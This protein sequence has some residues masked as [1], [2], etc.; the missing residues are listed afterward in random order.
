MRFGR[1]MLDALAL[2][3]FTAPIILCRDL[4]ISLRMRVIQIHYVS[5][6]DFKERDVTGVNYFFLA[7]EQCLAFLEP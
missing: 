3:D 4:R 5:L 7:D 6:L 1:M 2:R